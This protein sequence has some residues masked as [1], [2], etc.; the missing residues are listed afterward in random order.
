M[1]Y[2]K[3]LLAFDG[4]EGSQKALIHAMEHLENDIEVITVANPKD[5]IDNRMENLAQPEM[6]AHLNPMYSYISPLQIGQV[7]PRYSMDQ[8]KQESVLQMQEQEIEEEGNDILSI[9]RTM[10]PNEQGRMET[11]ILLG[12][13]PSEAICRYADE[14]EADL[15]IMG[16]RGI[17]GLKKLVLG[18]TSEQVLEKAD[19]P[20]CI[21]K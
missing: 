9:A 7:A 8:K 18:S 14:R 3:V 6:A 4:S 20:V 11:T 5:H 16:H 13:D 19:C 1:T 12:E 17:S 21:V 10:F 2:K 15:I